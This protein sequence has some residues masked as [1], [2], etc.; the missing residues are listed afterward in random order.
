MDKYDDIIR[1]EHEKLIFWAFNG[2]LTDKAIEDKHEELMRRIEE[3]F[4]D[5]QWKGFTL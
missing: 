5:R 2:S 1:E 4:I 3:G